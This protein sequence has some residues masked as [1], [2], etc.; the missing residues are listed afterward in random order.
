[1]D[2]INEKLDKTKKVTILIIYNNF[3]ETLVEI[4]RYTT[5]RNKN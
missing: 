4:N 2:L 3:I 1:M 5:T